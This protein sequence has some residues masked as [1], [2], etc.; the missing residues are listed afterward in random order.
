MSNKLV[1]TRNT[2]PHNDELYFFVEDSNG[3]TIP[4]KQTF[5]KVSGGQIRMSIEAGENVQILRGEL[6]ERSPELMTQA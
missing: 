1:L 4:I 6:L 5:T 3:S 2:K